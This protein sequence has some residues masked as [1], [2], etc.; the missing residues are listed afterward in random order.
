MSNASIDTSLAWLACS[1]PRE[2]RVERDTW[3]GGWPGLIARR[4]PNCGRAA[5]RAPK[6]ATV[7]HVANVAARPK[8]DKRW[9]HAMPVA[10][11]AIAFISP[12]IQ[13]VWS[14]LEV[15]LWSAACAALLKHDHCE[16]PV[17]RHSKLD[18]S[19]L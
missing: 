7:A 10:A 15:L 1:R 2:W 19:V 14:G 18:T 6:A 4:G 13:A 8:R 16:K 17:R 9:P 11:L 3:R 12:G 5:S